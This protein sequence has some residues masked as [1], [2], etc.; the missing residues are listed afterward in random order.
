MANE[1]FSTTVAKGA[2][3]RQKAITDYSNARNTQLAPLVA[4][5]NGDKENFR[6]EF[7]YTVKEGS[8]TGASGGSGSNST[9][10]AAA[11][12]AALTSLFI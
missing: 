2:A 9:S 3:L 12:G 7:G 6:E 5:L 11:A 8:T 1:L 4:L 10:E